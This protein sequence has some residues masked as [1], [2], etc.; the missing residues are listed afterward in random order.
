MAA[1]TRRLR[2]RPFQRVTGFFFVIEVKIFAHDIPT[3]RDMADIAVFRE[4][5]VRDHRPPVFIPIKS[6]VLGGVNES[7]T[8]Y[9]ECK[10]N[11]RTRHNIGPTI[12]ARNHDSHCTYFEAACIEPPILHWISVA[13][14][15]I[16]C[17]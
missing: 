3:L 12:T 6:F 16:P 11:K 13:Q 10:G 14:D 2:V 15:G 8:K 17:M 5:F 9:E 4:G 7:R 1:Q